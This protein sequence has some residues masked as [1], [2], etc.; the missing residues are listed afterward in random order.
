MLTGSSQRQQG[1]CLD[2]MSYTHQV[3]DYYKRKHATET[4][5]SI[6]PPDSDLAYTLRTPRK[7]KQNKSSALPN[8]MQLPKPTRLHQRQRQ[9][10][11]HNPN[12]PNNRPRHRSRPISPRIRLRRRPRRSS[13]HRHRHRTR[14]RRR[15]NSRRL[16]GR[17]VIRS[18]H[19]R[20]GDG[21]RPVAAAFR[22][23][24]G[25]RRHGVGDGACGR[26]G[27]FGHVAGAGGVVDYVG[28]CCCCCWG[29][30]G[31]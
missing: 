15:R 12:H 5:P 14:R 24:P 3:L 22:L 13:R 18:R 11:S 19:R 20:H 2:R 29:E 27:G 23:P 28:D 7:P 9:R 1:A 6:H 10:Q 16:H 8:R 26:E 30:R 31:G 4:K 17:R 25:V 21:G